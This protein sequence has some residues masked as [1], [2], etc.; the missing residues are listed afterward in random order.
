MMVGLLLAG[1]IAAPA[2]LAAPDAQE[3]LRQSDQARGGDLPD[4]PGKCGWPTAAAPARTC[5]LCGWT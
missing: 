5:S 4:S 3:L 1:L 2:A